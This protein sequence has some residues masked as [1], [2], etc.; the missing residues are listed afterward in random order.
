LYW[1]LRLNVALCEELDVPIYSL[2][3]SQMWVRSESV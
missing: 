1:R 2:I 3:L